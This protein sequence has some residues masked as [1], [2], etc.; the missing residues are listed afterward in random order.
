MWVAHMGPTCWPTMAPIGPHMQLFIGYV[1]ADAASSPP[2]TLATAHPRLQ[3]VQGSASTTPTSCRACHCN[4]QVKRTR[5]NAVDRLRW[6]TYRATLQVD[7]LIHT[8]S[9]TS[10]CGYV[11]ADAT[12]QSINDRC[13]L[14][15]RVFLFIPDSSSSF[16]IARF[17]VGGCGGSSS[18]LSRHT[19]GLREKLFQGGMKVNTGPKSY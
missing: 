18:K 12:Q 3:S 13:D 9:F 1:W 7:L 19:Q 8:S 14:C 6:T 5:P 11:G 17:S 2:F 10:T 16:F 15:W 4:V